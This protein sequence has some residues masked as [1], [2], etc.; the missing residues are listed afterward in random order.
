ME[1]IMRIKDDLIDMVNEQIAHSGMRAVETREMGEVIDM[2]KDLAEACYYCE[3]A[4]ETEMC[5]QYKMGDNYSGWGGQKQ[6]RMYYPPR[7]PINYNQGSNGGSGSY[8]GGNGTGGGRRGYNDNGMSSQEVEH[9]INDLSD[10]L[11]DMLKGIPPEDK[12]MFQQKIA[13]LANKIK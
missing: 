7:V 6:E 2:I 8:G 1:K 11:I 13:S 5:L 10:E 12:A 3:K 9:Y 4:K